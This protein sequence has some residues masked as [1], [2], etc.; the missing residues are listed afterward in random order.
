MVLREYFP[1]EY[2]VTKRKGPDMNGFLQAINRIN[3]LAAFLILFGGHLLMYFLLGTDKWM[4]V[5]LS[6]SLVDTAVLS[7]LQLLAVFK[8]RAK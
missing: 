3:L 8:N 6:A 7:G 4:T 5:A 1:Y 2:N